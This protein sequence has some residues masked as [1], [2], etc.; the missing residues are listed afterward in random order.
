M[1]ESPETLYVEVA[2]GTPE[3][4]RVVELHLPS[5]STVMQA[6]QSS[7]LA[8]VFPDFDADPSRLAVYGKKARPD[9]PLVEGD[10]VEVLRPLKVD[11]KEV[12]RARAEAQKASKGA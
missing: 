7:G 1:S 10:R 9:Q 12:R 8:D 4:Q 5:G 2:Y 11:P 6:V 3:R